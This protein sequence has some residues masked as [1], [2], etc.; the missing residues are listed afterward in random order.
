MNAMKKYRVTTPVLEARGNQVWEVEASS[1]E[2]A[3][4]KVMA[5][6]GEFLTEEI[7]VMHIGEPV[8]IEEVK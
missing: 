1:K 7:E 2:E 8:L 4:Q 3:S 5:G 6:E